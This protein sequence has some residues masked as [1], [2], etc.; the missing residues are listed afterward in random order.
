MLERSILTDIII[1]IW[2][3]Y[4]VQLEYDMIIYCSSDVS[5]SFRTL[6][7]LTSD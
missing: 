4:G 5:H 1:T 2:S 3:I 7:Y 6:C